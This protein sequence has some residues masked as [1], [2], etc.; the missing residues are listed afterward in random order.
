MLKYFPVQRDSGMFRFIWA[1]VCFNIV[2]AQDFGR[3]FNK[4]SLKN[5]VNVNFIEEDEARNYQNGDNFKS[6]C[7]FKMTKIKLKVTFM[8]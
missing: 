8:S 4:T 6:H 3:I 2:F 5:S 1:V 7:K